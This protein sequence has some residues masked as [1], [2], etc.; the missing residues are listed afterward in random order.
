M[1]RIHVKEIA[2]SPTVEERV[3]LSCRG[4][5]RV[6]DGPDIKD[7][8]FPSTP[9]YAE[10]YLA[11]LAVR[12]ADHHLD[13][14]RCVTGDGDSELVSAE[15]RHHVG[16]DLRRPTAVRAEQINIRRRACGH[17]VELDCVTSS[18]DEATVAHRV[19]RDPG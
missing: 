1:Y 10:V 2:W 12:R 7:N 15:R 13:K 3:H 18:Q 11:D 17:T 6:Q 5:V 4:V 9:E 19:Q 8:R 14:I 16:L